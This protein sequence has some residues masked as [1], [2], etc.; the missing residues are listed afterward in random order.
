MKYFKVLVISMFFSQFTYAEFINLNIIRVAD[1]ES[2]ACSLAGKMFKETVNNFEKA[3]YFGKMA[4]CQ[5]K[6]NDFSSK[7]LEEKTEIYNTNSAQK[8]K[9]LISALDNN[10]YA[11]NVLLILTGV[12]S[13]RYP[14]IFERLSKKELGVAFN[15]PQEVP[16]ENEGD[17]HEMGPAAFNTYYE[18]AM[19]YIVNDRNEDAERIIQEYGALPMFGQSGA[20][21]LEK[22]LVTFRGN[23]ERKR[24]RK[25]KE[26]AKKER[27]QNKAKKLASPNAT[28]KE[29]TNDVAESQ[30][31]SDEFSGK[32]EDKSPIN[33]YGLFILALIV[34]IGLFIYRR[35]KN[36]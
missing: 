30:V 6:T 26:A 24:A 14:G 33:K 31:V 12:E 1:G 16:D 28:K 34:A 5:Y 23:L 19:A 8:A 2:A 11:S 22:K 36:Q 7:N 15:T 25:K 9:Y 27:A 20:K 21:R 13:S 10:E 4:S 35:R 17:V 18:M 29:V 32:L 3:Y